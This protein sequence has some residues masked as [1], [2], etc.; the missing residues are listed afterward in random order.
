MRKSLLSTSVLACLF[1]SSTSGALAQDQFEDSKPSEPDCA[2]AAFYEACVDEEGNLNVPVIVADERLS[3]IYVNGDRLPENPGAVSFADRAQIE[4]TLADHPAEI[5]NT[6]PGVNIHT[7]SGQEHLIAIRSP[8]LNGGAGQGSFLILQNGVSTRSPAFG[9]VN[10]LFETHHEIADAIEVVRGPSSAAHGSNAVHGLVNIILPQD[11]GYNRS[12]A[13]LSASTLDRYR[14]DLINE[15]DAF[16][17]A[18]S[19]QHDA[20]WR[21]DTSVDQQKLYLSTEFDLGDWGA[22]AWLSAMNL[23]QETGGFIQGFEAYEDEGVSESNPNPEAFRDAQFAMAA[24]SFTNDLGQFDADIKPYAR[25]Q[26]MEFRQHFLPYKGYEENS[27][28]AVGVQG[29]AETWLGDNAN[30]RIGG[31]V[32]LASGDLLETQPDAFGFFPGDSRFPEGVHYDYTVDTQA[33]ALWGELDYSFTDDVRVL[34]GLRAET[35][36]FQY[37]TRAPAGVNGRFNVPENRDDSFDL[38]TPKLGIIWDDAIG[39]VAIYA[40]YARGQRAPQ[41]SDLYRLQSLQT[42]GEVKSETLDSVEIGARGAVFDGRLYFDIAA[43]VMEKEN[44]FFRDSDGLNVIDGRTDH[45]GIELQ[46]NLEVTDTLTVSGTLSW[47]DHTYAFDRPAN[48][49]VSGNQIDTAPE[50]LS[51]LRLAWQPTARLSTSLGLEY[52]GEYFTDEANSA[53][54]DGHTLTNARASYEIRD[55]VEVFV[56]VRNLFDI[57]YADRADYAFGNHRYFPGEPMNATFGVRASLN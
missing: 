19:V 16:L 31:L 50:W 23:N 28:H 27:H 10:S 22:E 17:G 51:D 44:V 29:E 15:N 36:E 48:G 8:V 14:A 52:V 56:I 26:Q 30:F 7:N 38:V 40:N 6:L 43:Y 39:E 4:E 9:N 47:A 37:T 25:W 24:V 13:T 57:R 42:V 5:L 54:Y 55:E 49:I 20:G 2:D 41:A 21:D 1:F 32:D 33:Y 45:Q 34:A 11:M 3:G 18:L 46:A 53:M 12:R 35:H